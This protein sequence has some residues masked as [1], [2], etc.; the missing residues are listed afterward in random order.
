MVQYI[1][2]ESGRLE[3]LTDRYLTYAR[4]GSLRLTEVDP[5]DLIE[6]AAT[7]LERSE[8]HAGITVRIEIEDGLPVFQGDP[9]LLRQVLLNLSWNAVE[10]MGANGVITLFAR[11][12]SVDSDM[13]DLLI[14][15]EDTGPGIPESLRDR[16]FDPFFS[17]RADGNGLGLYI[18]HGII[19]AHGGEVATETAPEG[20]ARFVFRLPIGQG[21][22]L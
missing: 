15:V 13:S 5:R 19:S 1:E 22:D 8:P 16:I 20:G 17:T 14:G 9:D 18:V 7:A 21:D 11:R 3:D 2:E 4:H 12:G 10:A 6:S